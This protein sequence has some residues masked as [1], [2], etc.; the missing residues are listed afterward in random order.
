MARVYR[1]QSLYDKAIECC[2]KALTMAK[3]VYGTDSKHHD[4][5]KVYNNFGTSTKTKVG[6][7]K[8]TNTTRLL[9][10][11]SSLYLVKTQTTLIYA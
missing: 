11:T 10:N 6:M 9:W 2:N 7:K 8:P 1:R 5:A 3:L 4:L